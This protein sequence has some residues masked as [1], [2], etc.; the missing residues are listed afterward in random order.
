MPAVLF[1]QHPRA[2]HDVPRLGAVK[3][4]G[5]HIA[6]HFLHIGLREGLQRR[7]TR[8]ERGC[9]HID[10]LIGALGGEAHGKE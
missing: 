7:E 10:P 1:Q 8:V 5:V 6:L 2:G 4:A 9:H 3:A